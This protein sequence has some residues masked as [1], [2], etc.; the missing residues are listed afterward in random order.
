MSLVSAV[1]LALLAAPTTARELTS[2][3]RLRGGKLSREDII[4]KLNKVPTFAIC[5][6]ESNVVPV[7]MDGTN[8]DI[9]WF[10][11]AAEAKHLLELTRAANEDKEFHLAVTPLGL[12]F[13]KCHGFEDDDE[14]ESSSD[15][16]LQGNLKIRGPRK[17]V[18]ASEAALRSQAAA[19]GLSD[20][21]WVLP[22]YCHDDFQTDKIMPFFFSTNDFA[23]GWTRFGKAADACP[24]NLT[25]MDL[26][27]LVKQMSET[28]VFPWHIFQF[29]TSEE[30]YALAAELIA[31]QQAL[32]GVS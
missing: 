17:A 24:D 1:A 9:C 20:A 29:V 13:V 12:A 25:V 15:G 4:D 3:T 26:R 10:T 14:E 23:A 8:Q 2:L 28:D 27:V 6:T 18:E 31:E 21:S 5:D 16:Y 22:V 19:Q 30:G 7:C 11:D 32:D